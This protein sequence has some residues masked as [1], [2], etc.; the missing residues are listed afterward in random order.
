MKKL[1]RFACVVTTSTTNG[2]RGNSV[3]ANEWQSFR[4]NTTQRS[5]TTLKIHAALMEIS[6][7]RRW[8]EAGEALR[9]MTA[10]N[11]TIPLLCTLHT[12]NTALKQGTTKNVTD[13][14]LCTVI[15]V[16]LTLL[17]YKIIL[18]DVIS[19]ILCMNSQHNKIYLCPH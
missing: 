19:R 18:L 15:S 9:T 6:L 16:R 14:T 12:T 5:I 7:R 1:C 11:F 4:V 2:L 10:Q 8:V 17:N 3:S 13:L